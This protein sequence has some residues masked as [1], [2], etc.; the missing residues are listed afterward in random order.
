MV[1]ERRREC[2]EDLYSWIEP[3]GPLFISTLRL[4]ELLDL[5]L[6]HVENVV[7]RIAVLKLGSEWVITKIL[8]HMSFVRS[9]GIIE[10]KLEVG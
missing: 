8:L 9:Q 10:N 5:V 2:M 4:I 7:R 6:K 1:S 3:T